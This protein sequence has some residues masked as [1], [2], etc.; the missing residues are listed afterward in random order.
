M[1][2]EKGNPEYNKLFKV[3]TY[4]YPPVPFYLLSI[5]YTA[6]LHAPTVTVGSKMLLFV[7][8]IS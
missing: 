6:P 2:G 4:I 1:G 5:C 7:S 8:N 3:A